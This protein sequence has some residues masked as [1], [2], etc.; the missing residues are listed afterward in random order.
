MP[1]KL[2]YSRRSHLLSCL[3]CCNSSDAKVLCAAMANDNQCRDPP[4]VD[5]WRRLIGTRLHRAQQLTE[6]AAVLAPIHAAITRA[7]PSL[8][9]APSCPPTRVQRFPRPS[10]PQPPVSHRQDLPHQQPAP[11]TPAG[12]CRT[13][14]TSRKE[15][16][17]TP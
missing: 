17:A 10:G 8:I 13:G 9:T 14:A 12:A 1:R 6:A 5:G 3:N 16:P 11:P 15:N 2:M 7:R 4:P